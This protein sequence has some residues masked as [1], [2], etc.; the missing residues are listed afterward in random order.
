MNIFIHAK[1][2]YKLTI[3]PSA[4]FLL[5]CPDTKLIIFTGT[6]LVTVFCWEKK[7]QDKHKLTTFAQTHRKQVYFFIEQ[8]NSLRV[9]QNKTKISPRIDYSPF[10]L[11]FLCFSDAP[12]RCFWLPGSA[13]RNNWIWSK[14]THYMSTC[15]LYKKQMFVKHFY[16]YT[17]LTNF[18]GFSMY[19][20]DLHNIILLPC[21]F[22]SVSLHQVSFLYCE[23]QSS[24]NLECFFKW[25]SP[26]MIRLYY[27]LLHAYLT[28]A[29]VDNIHL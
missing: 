17:K 5:C 26:S 25:W 15:T 4:F 18:C 22:L 12:T 19:F 9:Q 20:R 21:I 6:N 2:R 27:F 29:S 1:H 23:F 13:A 28:N 24:F 11:I 7:F 8:A 16:M 3:T 14:D 10:Y